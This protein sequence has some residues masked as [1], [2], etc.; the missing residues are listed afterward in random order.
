[1]KFTRRPVTTSSP[2]TTPIDELASLKGAI[3][4][5]PFDAEIDASFNAVACASS[6]QL[7]AG[8][9]QVSDRR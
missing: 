7:S 5:M 9:N 1:M 2:G 6:F 8:L 4:D 3:S